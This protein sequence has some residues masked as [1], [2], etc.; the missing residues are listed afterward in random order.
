MFRQ[1]R[2]LR[3]WAA[4]VLLAW[5][6]GVASGVAHACLAPSADGPGGHRVAAPV[7][8]AHGQSALPGNDPHHGSHQADAGDLDHGGTL[9]KSNCQDFCEKS[10]VS[11]PPQKSGLDAGGH[12]LAPPFA[13]VVF[14]V[15][16]AARLLPLLRHRPG[17]LAPPI[18]IAFL[19]LAL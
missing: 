12:A 10:A 5:L 13:A 14:P 6:F 19:R 1:R 9:G 4:W 17:A 3:H 11:V 7:G 2:Q 18:P 16:A 15:H 8:E